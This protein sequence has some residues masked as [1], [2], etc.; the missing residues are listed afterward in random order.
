MELEEIKQKWQTRSTVNYSDEELA[1]IYSIRKNRVLG[2]Y[3]FGLS[4]DLIIAELVALGFIVVLQVLDL[5][6]SNFW[7]FTMAFFALQ[8]LVLY[9][10]QVYFI[11]KQTK[12]TSNVN[13]SIASSVKKLTVLLW[14][15]RLWPML[16]TAGLYL[17]YILSF[18]S[19]LSSIEIWGIG[20]M[21]I[22]LV[23]IISNSLGAVLVRT[24]LARLNKILESYDL[25]TNEDGSN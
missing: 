8:H 25:S 7:S 15:Y 2:N 21:L 9:Q 17:I 24:H 11:R 23:A 12:F 16:F 4:I 6:S 13:T 3:T 22:L 20:V 19:A 14:H 18:G 5:S 1:S 10:V